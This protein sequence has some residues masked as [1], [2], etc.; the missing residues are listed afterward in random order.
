M[1]NKKASK[2]YEELLS[3]QDYLVVQANDLA[4]AFGN[5]KAFEHKILDFCF[6]YITKESQASDT[7]TLDA[8]SIFKHFGLT[9][10]GQNY[11]RVAEAFKT[12]NENTALY[13]P[14]TKENGTKGIVMTQ[15]FSEIIF[16]EKGKI[17]FKFSSRA[18]PLIFDLK[19]NFYSFHLRELTTIKSKYGLI[20]LKLW[21]SNR[22]GEKRNTVINGTMEEWQEWFLGKKK[23]WSAG[24]FK[25]K[26]LQVA[27]EEIE[28]KLDVDIMITTHKRGR[29]V[30]GY[31]MIIVDNRQNRPVDF[32]RDIKN[33]EISLF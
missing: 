25:Q 21:E 20:L 32:Y 12:L 27:S 4:K 5:L 9:K 26:V 18:I 30:I 16:D 14:I 1:E 8:I 2:V 28:S 19:K 17:D 33:G 23:K 29:E 11:R 7:F 10:N 24:R 3:R 22:F 31:E 15:L 6:S 13:L